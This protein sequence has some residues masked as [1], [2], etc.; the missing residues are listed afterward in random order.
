MTIP[1]WT[2]G[3]FRANIQY[4]D[5]V[6]EELM[7]EIEE[8]MQ[9]EMCIITDNDESLE[10]SDFIKPHVEDLIRN[11][12]KATDNAGLNKTHILKFKNLDASVSGVFFKFV[13]FEIE[14]TLSEATLS[15]NFSMLAFAI[16][17][18]QKVLGLICI[19]EYQYKGKTTAYLIVGMNLGDASNPIMLYRDG[20]GNPVPKQKMKLL[21]PQYPP[22]TPVRKI[23]YR[24][25]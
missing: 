2:L 15:N 16:P 4:D 24:G 23:T 1:K 3:Q 9:S 10:L 13:D 6:S 7:D 25:R 17:H 14:V 11:L 21:I 5:G 12:E 18:S 19:N 22:G 8:K 20:N